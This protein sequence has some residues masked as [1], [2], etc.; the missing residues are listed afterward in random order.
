MT[1]SVFDSWPEQFTPPMRMVVDP[2]QP[3]TVDLAAAI[4][5]RPTHFRVDAVPLRVRQGGLRL[6]DT[7]AGLLHAWAR[8]SDGTWLALVTFTLRTGN[9]QGLLHLEQWCPQHAVTHQHRPHR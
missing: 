2:P 5:T 8:V 1:S 3:V 6:T 9:G 7:T 4:T